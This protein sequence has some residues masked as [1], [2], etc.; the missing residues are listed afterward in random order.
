MPQWSWSFWKTAKNCSF[1]FIKWKPLIRET[2][3]L[4]LFLGN[5]IGLKFHLCYFCVKTLRF[6]DMQHFPRQ[7]MIRTHCG[8]G[9][10][11]PI[12]MKLCQ[13]HLLANR[14][15]LWGSAPK[16][17]EW[18]LSC[19][20]LMSIIHFSAKFVKIAYLWRSILA[21]RLNWV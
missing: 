17:E 3:F 14:Q 15:L 19:D 21:K 11:C 10:R 9:Y 20:Q 18:F 6:E 13:S 8:T 2:W 16:S 12:K 1:S 4:S 5:F 7:D